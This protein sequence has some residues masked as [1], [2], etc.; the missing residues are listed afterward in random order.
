M[1][2]RCREQPPRQAE[3]APEIKAEGYAIIPDKKGLALTAFTS[4]GVFYALQTVKQLIEGNGS[5]AILHTA[6]YPRL[7]RPAVSRPR[8]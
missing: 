1:P 7:A 5:S 8:R 3:P 6:D 4:S 2:S